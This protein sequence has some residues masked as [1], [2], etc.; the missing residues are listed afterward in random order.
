MTRPSLVRLLSL[1]TVLLACSSA[2]VARADTFD[3]AATFHSIGITMRPDATPGSTERAAVRYRRQGTT[4]WQ[5]GDGLLPVWSMPDSA[6]PFA[7]HAELSGS[8]LMLY[9]GTTY[10]IEITLRG[11]ATTIEA[12]TWSERFPVARTVTV[13]SS[14]TPLVIDEGSGGS[15]AD[16]YVVYEGEPSAVIDPGASGDACVVVRA[17]FVIVRGLTLRNCGPYGV[18]LQPADGV[19]SLH[20]VVIEDNDISG[21]GT[22]DPASGFGHDYQ[23]AVYSSDTVERI[24]V[25]RNVMHNPA[26][27]TNS[28]LEQSAACG[29]PTGPSYECHPE[30][31]QA[32][33]WFDSPG[34]NV[35][36]Y[37]RVY[38][39]PDHRYNDIFGGGSN[40]SFVGFP[41][42]NSDIY[43]NDISDGWED[44]IESE[45]GNHNVRIWGNHIERTYVGIAAATASLGP[46][47]VFRN[48]RGDAR[49]N[50]VDWMGNPVAD[51]SDAMLHGGFLKTA[52]RRY[53]ENG[54]GTV[55]VGD[56]LQEISSAA[57][58]GTDSAGPI[59]VFHNT[60]YQ[61][62]S[63]TTGAL[64]GVSGFVSAHQAIVR[65]VWSRNN[66]VQIQP[67]WS[68]A[69]PMDPSDI[70][71]VVP[72]DIRN[73]WDY[74]LIDARSPGTPPAGSPAAAYE[75]HGH[76]ETS[77]TFVSTD[78]SDL[79]LEL[80]SVGQ[81]QGVALPGLNDGFAGA[82]PDIG[83][84]EQGAPPLEFGQD[85]YRNR[86]PVA[87]ADATAAADGVHLDATRSTDS[88]GWIR[89]VRWSEAGARL[90][91][92]ATAVVAFSTG[93]HTIDV[94]VEDNVGAVGTTALS[95]VVDDGGVIVVDGGAASDGGLAAPVDGAARADGGVGPDART[96]TGG[97]GCRVGARPSRPT[98]LGLVLS[99][100]MA[101]ALTRGRAR[102]M[103]RRVALD[104]QS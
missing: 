41:G 40:F 73:D 68:F 83:A 39:D 17:S 34:S 46:L 79:R 67:G 55:G 54:D 60:V 11:A 102:R 28:W 88:D 18:R 32:V 71:G 85:A 57:A 65:N 2:A 84:F 19:A 43:A 87:V 70:G 48:V 16:G 72:A 77:P 6:A 44:A 50:D 21:W 99:F 24:V 13:P 8:L 35:I 1:S 49:G 45:G 58:S 20:D 29:P 63:A 93:A 14:G 5:T 3:T 91:T 90:A 80:G 27:D 74:D 66:V 53:L 86:V 37:N 62:R 38:S 101:V 42:A 47:Y 12:S 31:P 36:R 92:G 15:S 10:E 56:L 26:T 64:N 25:Q 96:M 75:E 9:S 52:P 100:M 76:F 78:P 69:W 94:E 81:D 4:E 89:D 82:A 61:P 104:E 59:R 97:C 30:G 95:I 33:V 51:D 98:G 22:V 103:A 7:R 23:G